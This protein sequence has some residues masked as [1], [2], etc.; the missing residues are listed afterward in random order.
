[1]V[2]KY[3]LFA[4]LVFSATIPGYA[5]EDE[6]LNIIDVGN[7]ALWIEFAENM[8]YVANPVD[9]VIIIID[10]GTGQIT[11]SIDAKE[12]ISVLEI[13]ED[14]NTIYATVDGQAPIVMFDT[15]TGE[16]LGEIDIGEAEITL[17]ST[18]DQ[19]YGQRE[20]VTFNT[21]AIGLAYNP[22]TGMLYAAHTTV[23]K[24]NVI[25]TSTNTNVAEIPVGKS[26]LLITIDE[27]RNMAYVT[28]RES[29]T[30]SVIDLNTNTVIKSLQTGFAGNQ[31]RIDSVNDMLYVTHHASPHVTA[32][33]LATHEIEEKIQLAGPTHAIAFDEKYSLLHVTY[34]PESGVTGAGATGMVEFIN[35][36]TNEHVG[37]LDLPENPFTISIHPETRNLFASILNKGTVVRANLDEYPEYQ[38]ILDKIKPQEQASLS[39]GGGCLIATAAYGTE[40][41]PQV[42]MLRETR[43][44][45][46]MST[47]SGKSFMA[48]FNSVYYSF[49]PHVADLERENPAFR[50]AVRAFITP[51]VSSLAIMSLA[52]DGSE[53]HV[54]GL[55]I[56]V[57]ALNLGMYVA[58]PALAVFCIRR[59]I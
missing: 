26:P 6:N 30:V 44:N 19:P 51:M 24:I 41:A 2:I 27:S 13:A 17:Y 47:E 32:V 16:N 50:E 15:D 57:I 20:Y 31:M 8:A 59:R 43:D 14:K 11:D 52:Q 4:L 12:G 7:S 18:S 38:A 48:A 29:S 36:N 53:S 9:G 22:H 1:M 46:I 35:T 58:A 5:Q 34:I 10:I 23:N 40:L 56:A 3:A 33:N 55:G 39:P 42:Q 25:D 21:N 28:N 37:S 45:T 49:S 54:L